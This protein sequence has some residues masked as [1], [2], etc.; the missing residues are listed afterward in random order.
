MNPKESRNNCSE[1]G[2]RSL[3][4]I[5]ELE[6]LTTPGMIICHISLLAGID[7]ANDCSLKVIGSDGHLRLVGWQRLLGARGDSQGK[8][9]EQ[10][11]YSP[12]PDE[13]CE[14]YNIPAPHSLAFS[15]MMREVCR[16]TVRL[17]VYLKVRC[18]GL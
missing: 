17:I 18:V 10:E 11:L 15:R 4:G 2:E 14:D 16:L 12:V 9:P 5:L 7:G 6:S 1:L 8:E 3:T 13:H